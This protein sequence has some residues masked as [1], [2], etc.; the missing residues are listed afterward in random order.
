M[1][2]PSEVAWVI[3]LQRNASFLEGR[4]SL[5]DSLLDS[6][7]HP[8]DTVSPVVDGKRRQEN[9]AEGEGWGEG[10]SDAQGPGLRVKF[11]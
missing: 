3:L 6:N 1:R 5:R 7:R 9:E 2:V 11:K 4:C 8:L 10:N